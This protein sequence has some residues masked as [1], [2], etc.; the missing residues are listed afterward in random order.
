MEGDAQNTPTHEL[1]Y[2]PSLHSVTFVTSRLKKEGIRNIL[3]SVLP[4]WNIPINVYIDVLK[5][6]TLSIYYVRVHMLLKIK[7][8][9]ICTLNIIQ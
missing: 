6:I 3:Y 5:C 2:I 8:S 1:V 4:T 7:N 9:D